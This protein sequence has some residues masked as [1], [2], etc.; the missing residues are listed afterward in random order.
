[1]VSQIGRQQI[2]LRGLR[3]ALAWVSLPA[4]SPFCRKIWSF[5]K[6]ADGG[7]HP[8]GEEANGEGSP[9]LLLVPY[10][11]AQDPLIT[12][13]AADGAWSPW[14]TLLRRT[15]AFLN[16]VFVAPADA[17]CSSTA[18]SASRAPPPGPT[19]GHL[20]RTSSLHQPPSQW[21]SQ[22]RALR[23]GGRDIDK[24]MFGEF[25]CRRTNVFS[26]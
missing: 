25:S 8:T 26:F 9:G 16:F 17:S 24:V 14:G 21:R 11:Q 22:Q 1:M 10:K 7:L 12:V 20:Q 19:W 13:Q 5:D 15:P 23:R 6:Q 4:G 3:G 2:R 18:L